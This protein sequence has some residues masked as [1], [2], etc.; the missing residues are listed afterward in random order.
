MK[1]SKKPHARLWLQ[2]MRQLL[3]QID[4]DILKPKK[5]NVNAHNFNII[6]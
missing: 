6:Y 5:D 1:S 4:V 3:E 2:L